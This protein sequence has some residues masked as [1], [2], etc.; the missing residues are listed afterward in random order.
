MKKTDTRPD[1][2]IKGCV[3]VPVAKADGIRVDVKT[4]PPD[5]F[6]RYDVARQGVGKFRCLVAYMP[7]QYGDTAH[8]VAW[9]NCA[10]CSRPITG[11][12]CSSGAYLPRS[13][14]YIYDQSVALA[15]GEE[16]GVHH[17][18]Y[19]GT[20]RKK[21]RNDTKDVPRLTVRPSKQVAENEQTLDRMMT[22]EEATR[23]E[24]KVLRS[25]RVKAAAAR[26]AAKKGT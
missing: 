4:L 5:T 24:R 16:W 12:Q 18:H 14:E 17:P 25:M 6:A 15:N 8:G 3:I 2:R 9:D 7:D 19:A 1:P 21:V 13:V 22:P 11:C 20:L 23:E 26:R 10:R